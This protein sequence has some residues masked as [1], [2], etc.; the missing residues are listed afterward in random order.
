MLQHELLCVEHL[1]QSA[2]GETLREDLLRLFG[3]GP[4]GQRP[5]YNLLWSDAARPSLDDLEHR[6]QIEVPQDCAYVEGH[7]PGYP[8]FPAAAQLSAMVLP[9]VRRVQPQWHSLKRMVRLKFLDRITPGDQ[10]L[11]ELKLKR[12]S[13][14]VD[15]SLSKQGVLCSAGTLELSSA[16]SA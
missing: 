1:P 3:L 13:C 11:L 12:D 16:K 15:F 7:F 14:I 5:N 2:D 9:A 4:S 10:V 8:I 6:F